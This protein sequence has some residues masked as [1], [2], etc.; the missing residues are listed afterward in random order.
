M[1]MHCMTY[2]VIYD[3]NKNKVIH[4]RQIQNNLYKFYFRVKLLQSK[5]SCTFFY[6]KCKKLFD[7]KTY[8]F[9]CKNEKCLK[10]LKT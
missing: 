1:F 10:Y 9:V 5:K 8:I 4:C 6:F 7:I 2:S 3:T